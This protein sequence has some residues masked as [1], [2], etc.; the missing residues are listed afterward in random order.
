MTA[1]QEATNAGWRLDFKLFANEDP[2]LGQVR[3]W[4]C[5]LEIIDVDD[6]ENPELRMPVHTGPP[7]HLFEPDAIELLGQETIEDVRSILV[8]VQGLQ[9]PN[10]GVLHPRPRC[11][12]N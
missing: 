2:D 10:N 3:L 6:E 12:M 7:G 9:H 5:R 1:A 8:T 4:T 11:W